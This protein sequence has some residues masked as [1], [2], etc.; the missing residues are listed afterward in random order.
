MSLVVSLTFLTS[1]SLTENTGRLLSCRIKK[2]IN[3]V[4]IAG[5]PALMPSM[6]HIRRTLVTMPNDALSGMCCAFHAASNSGAA[7]AVNAPIASSIK[8]PQAM[9]ILRPAVL[10]G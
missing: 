3:A 5:I 9:F 6:L 2:A 4:V 10:A 7:D 1:G 8:R